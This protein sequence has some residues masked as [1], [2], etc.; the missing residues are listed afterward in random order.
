MCD[1][2]YVWSQSK[3]DLIADRFH[4]PGHVSDT[5]TDCEVD[6]VVPILLAETVC[7]TVAGEYR[8]NA[9]Q[10]WQRA[11]ES[12][13]V[14]DKATWLKLAQE[15]QRLAERLDPGTA[16]KGS[17]PMQDDAFVVPAVAWNSHSDPNEQLETE[18]ASGT[19][20]AIVDRFIEL[21]AKPRQ[22]TWHNTERAL[23]AWCK[24]WLNKPIN[25]ITKI[26][27][28]DLIEG[29]VAEG[30]HA[31]AAVTQAWVK[32]FWRWAYQ[33]D[34]VTDAVMEKVAVECQKRTRNKTYSE[35]EIIAAWRASNR[36]DVITR[37]Y[38]KLLILLAPRK[39]ALAQMRWCDLN[40]EVTVWTTPP[41]WV[42]QSKKRASEKKRTYVTPLPLLAQRVL[43]RLPKTDDRVFPAFEPKVYVIRK[44]VL[45]GGPDGDFHRW[46]HTIA[47][48]LQGQGYSEEDCGLV[49]NHAHAGTATAGYCHGYP[50]ARKRELLDKWAKY[51]ERISRRSTS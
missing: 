51:I 30:K 13:C 47:T 28:Y 26:D 16:R 42:K 39:G 27:A 8:R 31:K 44:L 32:T 7:M 3:A 14:A 48:W 22:R 15:W 46:R 20:G 21:Y 45:A 33:R 41:E 23:K 18:Q 25:E 24:P 1:S 38:F 19:Y 12:I 9:L 29:Y 50:I 6:L 10:C 37:A 17:V 43:K 35:D 5:R 11:S 4:D 49:L 34:L 36:L 40:A 2:F